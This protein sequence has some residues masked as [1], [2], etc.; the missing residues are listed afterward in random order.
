MNLDYLSLNDLVRIF[1]Y[2]FLTSWLGF[3]YFFKF[4]KKLCDKKF[5][6]SLIAAH[7]LI[8]FWIT[9]I[10]GFGS[11]D[12]QAGLIWIIPMRFDF[13]V[14]WLFQISRTLSL[15]GESIVVW[16]ALFFFLLGG[17]QYFLLGILL[18]LLWKHFYVK[19]QK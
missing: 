8:I 2:V 18:D 19:K 4:F 12:A 9:G 5:R 15:L 1:D 3:L 10:A 14:S 13:A 6:L 17:L 7:S 11:H 16:P